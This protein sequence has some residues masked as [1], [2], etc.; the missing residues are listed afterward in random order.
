M[1]LP[2]L[3][4]GNSHLY[5]LYYYYIIT[6]DC[7]LEKLQKEEKVDSDKTLF[8]LIFLDLV[9]LCESSTSLR[10]VRSGFSRV[11]GYMKGARLSSQQKT[12]PRIF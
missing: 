3:A 2:F 10:V 1:E 5:L 8:I 6:V 4:G 12:G 9:S 7:R 11:T